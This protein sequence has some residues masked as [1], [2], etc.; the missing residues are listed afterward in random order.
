MA[1]KY[2]KRKDGRY[3]VQ[4]QIG[5]QDNGRPKYKNIY[6]YTIKE[7]E[8]KSAV[9]RQEL[10]K[11]IIIDDQGLT[12]ETWALRWLEAYKSGKEYNTI[13][14]YRDI[15]RVHIIPG[16]GHYKLKELKAHHIQEMIN[17]KVS[18]G[19]TRTIEKIYLTI[20]QMLE[21]AVKNE[22]IYKNVAKNIVL[23]K[24]VKIKKR[25]LTEQEKGYVF[26][27]DFSDKEKAYV[28]LLLMTGLR[29]GESLA[30]LKTDIDLN[31]KT[32]TVNKSLIVKGNRAEIK[33][34]PK[35]DAGYRVIPIPDTAISALKSYLSNSNSIYVF[36]TA[37]AK[38]M[39]NSGFRYFWSKIIDKLN[40]AAGGGKHNGL[41][42]KALAPG[43]TPHMFRHTY[44]TSLY[45]SGVDIKT[46][47]YLLGHSSIKMTMDIYTHLDADKNVSAADKLNAFYEHA[48][49]SK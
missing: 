1:T 22:Y 32:V 17:Q 26:S 20:N 7:L 25:A 21:Q 49:A 5:I 28:Y 47:Q 6:G 27:A 8:D 35:T 48:I 46:A 37:H 11:G 19:L 30:L 38:L 2:K 24:K 34:S 18:K 10:E 9:F 4:V 42:A 44:A 29:K 41:M 12:V 23:P 13:K 40:V 31:K 16:I 15:I 36:P 45:Y 39:T 33:Y 14:M 43:I 3:L